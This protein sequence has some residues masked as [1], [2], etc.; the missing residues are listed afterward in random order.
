MF[1]LKYNNVFLDLAPNLDAEIERNSPL[2]LIDSVFAE[3]ST[4][5]TF[6]YSDNNARELGWYFFE[7]TIR[8]RKKIN[9]EVYDKGTYKCNATAV[10]ESAGMN[11]RHKGAS[12][13][14]GYL[15]IGVS[16][17]FQTIQTKKLTDLKLGGPRSI[18]FTTYEA[19]DGSNG[20][21]Q[22]LHLTWSAAPGVYDYVFPPI[23]ND[24]WTGSADDPFATG[25]M[26]ALDTA[27]HS[28]ATLQK[29][30]PVSPQVYVKFILECIFSE[31]GWTAD[32]TQL[33]DAQWEKLIL[34]SAKS[35]P[36]SEN[37]YVWN[38]GTLQFATTSTPVST[39]TFSLRDF[40]PDYT[41]AEFITALCMRYGWAPVIST[42]ERKCSFVA[43]K[44]IKNGIAK[45]WTQYA[46]AGTATQITVDEKIF[47]FENVFEG[48][49]NFPSEPDFAGWTIL[50]AV[51]EV[52][53]LPSTS[54][55]IYDESLIFVYKENQYYKVG[56]NE[57]ETQRIWV[58]FSDNIYNDIPGKEDA[59]DTFTTKCTTLPVYKTLLRTLHPPG[60]DVN[61]YA[62]FPL[63][64]QSK[65]EKFGIR[66]ML[67]HGMVCEAEDDGNLGTMYY[68]YASSY[69]LRHDTGVAADLD[70]SNVYRHIDEDG[71]D[72]G[73]INYWWQSWLDI[74]Y[75]TE[76]AVK[77]RF[78]LPLHETLQIK[79]ND[80]ILDKNIP[81]LIKQIIEP[82]PYKGFIECTLQ[83]ILLNKNAVVSATQ[84]YLRFE[85]ENYVYDQDLSITFFGV[86]YYYNNA[87]TA[88]IFVRAYADAACTIPLTLSS[89]PFK[90]KKTVNKEGVY[91]SEF[92][93][94]VLKI[95][96]NEIHIPV[97]FY[98]LIEYDYSDTI[99][100]G[101]PDGH[102][103]NVW[104][105]LPDAS[106]IIV[107]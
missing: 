85:Y 62:Y 26:N 68:P 13:A 10:I 28:Y 74:I 40:M 27:S 98:S 91:Y 22:H 43:L 65:F 99:S 61:Y 66:T 36:V 101:N 39:L 6:V 53:D 69:R 106:Y 20:W 4:P 44:E 76:D 60:G 102:Y 80:I 57:D 64:E 95:T 24:V 34:F 25:F 23:R 67:Y 52:S 8:Q 47:A 38:S 100:Y 83:R 42:T 41:C 104:E 45:D 9:V 5:I 75:F 82:L 89:F 50:P 15:L 90:Y 88:D 29:D 105:L 93:T 97:G 77:K 96:G 78:Y 3:Y 54:S 46:A 87:T 32:F 16:D 59:T 86:T 79:W 81:Y 48:N 51:N 21:W 12:N 1:Q 92:I 71:N 2:F 7:P 14:G 94:D 49:D 55:A 103:S 56:L 17:F 30:K 70:W 72:Y 33:N 31:S 37:T 63:C 58:V 11:Y 84:V 35:L 73:I 107:P 18:A 19:F